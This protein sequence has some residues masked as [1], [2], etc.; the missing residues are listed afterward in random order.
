MEHAPIYRS[1]KR[2]TR[3]S[4]IRWRRT[5]SLASAV[6][7]VAVSGIALGYH[8][9]AYSTD[10]P[11]SDTS[12]SRE[13]DLPFPGFSVQP[14]GRG[15]PDAMSALSSALL[16]RVPVGQAVV[17]SLGQPLGPLPFPVQQPAQQP[18]AQPSS[19]PFSEVDLPF[20]G[21][22]EVISDPSA[23]SIVAEA[24]DTVAA[25]EDVSSE[26][27]AVAEV[28]RAAPVAFTPRA[29]PVTVAAPEESVDAD[30]GFQAAA[31]QVDD[32]PPPAV[33]EAD[34]TTAPTARPSQPS[35]VK[36]VAPTKAP[37]QAPT[38]A[39]TPRP[40][41]DPVPVRV[42]KV[43]PVEKDPPPK[44]A[45]GRDE[46][47]QPEV[48]RPAPQPAVRAAPPKPD[49]PHANGKPND[50]KPNDNKGKGGDSKHGR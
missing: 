32:S 1:T 5:A 37:T 21:P 4:P 30:P 23:E 27:L 31:A 45:A 39:P 34:P 25:V 12:V 18:T 28:Q 17:E 47:K 13:T 43:I 40:T 50:N 14:Q 22:S 9:F 41:P 42:R 26:S 24:A 44:Q 3:A 2:L 49:E 20:L 6:I 10:R 8:G 35:P 19:T 46:N 29:V 11:E 7:G 38:V 36:T 15:H 16:A 48:R 33:V